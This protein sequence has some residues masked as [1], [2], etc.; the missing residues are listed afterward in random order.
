MKD[1]LVKQDVVFFGGFATS[2]YS[3]YMDTENPSVKKV[4]DFDV[5]CEDPILSAERL[6]RE[7]DIKNITIEKGKEMGGMTMDDE[8]FFNDSSNQNW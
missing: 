4:P 7:L 5:L 1:I 3:K 2:L 6:K 8:T